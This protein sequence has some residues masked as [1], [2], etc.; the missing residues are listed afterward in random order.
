MGNQSPINLD[1]GTFF[2]KKLICK[3]ANSRPPSPIILILLKT[4]F[5]A[6]TTSSPS[7]LI[8][9]MLII[10]TTQKD[11]FQDRLK[12]KRNHALTRMHKK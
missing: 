5:S 8:I 4:K 1:D 6:S 12:L 9:V 10:I 11:S 7:L 3:H 2:I